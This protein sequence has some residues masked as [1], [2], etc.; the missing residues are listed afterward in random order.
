M[1]K[2]AGAVLVLLAVCAAV[3]GARRLARGLREAASLEVVRGIRCT[4][5]AVVASIFALGLLTMHTG[6]F[7]LG[8]VFLAEELYETG[9]VIAAIRWGD[10]R[11]VDEGGAAGY[12]IET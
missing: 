9:V 7:V 1:T 5:V 4:V 8:G 10:R 11:A 12:R 3:R 2:I 6:L